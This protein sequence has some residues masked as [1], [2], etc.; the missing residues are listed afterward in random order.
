MPSRVC[1]AHVYC[2]ALT[3]AQ[4][5][6]TCVGCGLKSNVSIGVD[7]AVN[8][9]NGTCVPSPQDNCF[10]F[11]S[12]AMNFTV[13]DFELGAA[14]EVFLGKEISAGENYKYMP[15]GYLFAPRLY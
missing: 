14:L 8:V 12:M 1:V 7:F 5:E 11:S 13:A 6:L 3:D 9:D 10:E 4:L 15:L 2:S